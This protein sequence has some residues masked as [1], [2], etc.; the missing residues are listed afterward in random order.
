MELQKR[1]PS[2]EQIS[3]PNL[4]TPNLPEQERRLLVSQLSNIIPA[5]RTSFY[6][7]QIVPI[8]EFDCTQDNYESYVL[9]DPSRIILYKKNRDANASNIIIGEAYHAPVLEC[10]G[11]IDQDLLDVLYQRVKSK[12][13]VITKRDI[14]ETNY[15]LPHHHANITFRFN[16]GILGIITID[17]EPVKIPIDIYTSIKTYKIRNS[18]LVL[19]SGNIVMFGYPVDR[20]SIY[21]QSEEGYSSALGCMLDEFYRMVKV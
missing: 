6:Q 3:F 13:P 12:T 14:P 17:N 20:T 1:M 11:K 8:R 10:I 2:N 7:P 9:G 21:T 15:T 18:Y 5:F 16:K 19:P 4:E